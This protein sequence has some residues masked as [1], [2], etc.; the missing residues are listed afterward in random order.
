LAAASQR[1][2]DAFK[3]QAE[4]LEAM[5]KTNSKGQRL[6]NTDPKYQKW[7]EQTLARSNY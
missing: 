2:R 7:F 1:K 4:M 6:Y 5:R 3:S